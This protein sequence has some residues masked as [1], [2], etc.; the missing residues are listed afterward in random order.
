MNILAEPLA[1]Y[2]ILWENRDLQFIKK[3]FRAAPRIVQL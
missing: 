1:N 2:I 3:N